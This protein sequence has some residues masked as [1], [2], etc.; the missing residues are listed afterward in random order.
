[1]PKLRSIVIKRNEESPSVEV[2]YPLRGFFD[3]FNRLVLI[4]F[5]FQLLV[6]LIDLVTIVKVV[7]GPNGKED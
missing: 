2:S 6:N 7:A 1:M 5:L 3:C 4:F